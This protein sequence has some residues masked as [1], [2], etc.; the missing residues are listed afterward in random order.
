MAAAPDILSLPGKMDA[1]AAKS[2]M[3]AFLRRKDRAILVDAS[4]VQQMSTLCVQ[5]LLSARK[6]WERDG[7]AFSV[8]DP[9]PTFREGVTMLGAETLLS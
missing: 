6:C 3:E 1:D 7:L 8:S 9:S 5:V 4:E 2:L